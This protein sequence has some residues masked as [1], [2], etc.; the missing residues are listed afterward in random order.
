MPG[1]AVVTG[2]SS[3]IG[4]AFAERLAGDGWDLLLVARRRERLQA[5]GARLHAAHGVQVRPL[6]A[7]LGRADDVE[8]LCGEVD[9]SAPELL[10]NN[11]GLAHYAPFAELDPR[12]AGEL[13]AVNAL[14]PVLLTR[15]AV[16]GMLARRRGSVVNVASL[17]AFSGSADLPH[18]PARAVYAATKA[19]LVTFTEVLASEVRGTGLRVQVVCPGVVRS[20]FH[21]RQGMDLSGVPRM[22][23]D[24][25]VDASLADL[26]RGVVVSIPGS[27]GPDA[28]TDLAAAQAALLS[29]SRATDLPPRYDAP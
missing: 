13:V 10:V 2:A 18:L 15:A 4:Q 25:V 3:G 7:D 11:A 24:R 28:Y 21:S 23:P 8:R 22:E 12:R 6:A 1:L 29:A 9:R 5:L 17:L 27:A 16:P 20:E 26:D 19:F 14:A